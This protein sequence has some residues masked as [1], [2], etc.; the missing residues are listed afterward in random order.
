ML[1]T[2]GSPTLARIVTPGTDGILVICTRSKLQYA[3]A[4]G[5]ELTPSVRALFCCS[6]VLSEYLGTGKTLG[7]SQPDAG[8]L[9]NSCESQCF[10]VLD[11]D[12]ES[13]SKIERARERTRLYLVYSAVHSAR[14]KTGS[15]RYRLTA[16]PGRMSSRRRRRSS[17]LFKFNDTRMSHTGSRTYHTKESSP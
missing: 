11:E 6:N 13:K 10:F 8:P 3:C 1:T 12:S 7:A 15:C 9:H 14:Y 5:C 2:R 4:R 17:S 16:V